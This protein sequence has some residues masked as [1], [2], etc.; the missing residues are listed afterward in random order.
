MLSSPR[1][2]TG[3]AMPKITEEIRALMPPMEAVDTAY[4]PAFAKIA[5]LLLNRAHLMIGGEAHR[6]TE[7]EFYFNGGDHLDKYTHGDKMQKKFGVWYFHKFGGEYKSGS[8]KGLDIAI[9]NDK[10]PA[11][12]LL[13]GH[14]RISDKDLIDGPSMSVDRMLQLN[15]CASVVELVK[16]LEKYD[17]SIDQGDDNSSPLCVV[18]AENRNHPVYSTARV[19]LTLKKENSVARWRYI[20]R[21]YRFITEP[22]RIKKGKFHMALGL[23]QQGKTIA[24]IAKL[25]GS[26]ESSV[27]GYI[28][29]YETG[30]AK[31]PSTFGA[32]LGTDELCSL[33]GACQKYI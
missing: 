18:P 2:K 3:G 23:H 28:E 22:S 8:Y 19:G 33:F 13:R 20:A 32:E 26:K 10:A 9:G 11:G 1:L 4:P 27:R 17:L 7:I 14:E 24:E 12:I 5:D 15:S 6:L 21:N 16:K 30:K 31:E 25:T 29:T